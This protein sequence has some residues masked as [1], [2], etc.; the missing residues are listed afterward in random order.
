M[1]LAR[2]Y[3]NE[4]LETKRQAILRKLAA[5]SLLKESKNKISSFTEKI[6]KTYKESKIA[7]Y[8]RTYPHRTDW[9]LDLFDELPSIDEKDCFYRLL[10]I[11]DKETNFS[12]DLKYSQKFIIGC[13]E[14]AYWGLFWVREPETWKS[15]THNIERQFESILHHLLSRYRVPVFLNKSFYDGNHINRKHQEWF[16][17]IGCGQ[18]I[19]NATNL[20][21]PITRMMAH[22]LLETPKNFSVLEAFRFARMKTLGANKNIIQGWLGSRMA[23]NFENQDFW[24]TVVKFFVENPMLDPEQI[25]SIIDYI[26]NQ[27]FVD[28]DEIVNNRVISSKPAQP[29]F[30]MKGRDPE[31]LL[32]QVERWHRLIAIQAGIIPTEWKHCSIPD[33]IFEEGS[34]I[35]RRVYR[36]SE[37]LSSAELKMEGKTMHHC[38]GSYSRSCAT[39]SR[40][41]FSLCQIEGRDCGNKATISVNL[42]TPK[43][44]SEAR[45]KYNEILPVNISRIIRLW[46]NKHGIQISSWANI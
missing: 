22:N 8:S 33:G 27:K 45:G 41:I 32:E 46:A 13:K 10:K 39:R 37:L 15:K 12:D 36:I 20:P 17:H 24:D 16:I 42:S 4:N 35:G 26:Y 38:V 21:M 3:K 29:N 23:T 40:A 28:V 14:I 18:N 34:G 19:R 9:L 43:I 5:D 25:P 31:S 2:K 7:K 1:D 11:I 44:I 30:C 6:E